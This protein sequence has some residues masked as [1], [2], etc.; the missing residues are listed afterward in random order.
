MTD[1]ERPFVP[2]AIASVQ[3]QTVETPIILCVDET[4]TWIHDVLAGLDAGITLLQVPLAPPGVVRN[5]ALYLV[6]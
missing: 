3:R 4:N 6:V 2:E 1:A 5:A